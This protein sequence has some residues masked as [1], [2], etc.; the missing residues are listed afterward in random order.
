MLF[1]EMGELWRKAQYADALRPAEQILEMYRRF[2]GPENIA[3]AVAA[4]WC[5]QLLNL[6]ARYADAEKQFREALRIV[7][8]VVGEDSP[9]AAALYGNLALSL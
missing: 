7:L 4:N 1:D 6:S 9:G 2:L 5:G 8:Q 3:V